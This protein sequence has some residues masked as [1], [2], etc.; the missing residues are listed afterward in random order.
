MDHI[1]AGKRGSNLPENLRI[2]CPVCHALRDDGYH[3]RLLTEM[4]EAGQMPE[5]WWLY[6]WD[7]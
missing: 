3:Y 1:R 5:E 6:K 7:R 4:I 2:L